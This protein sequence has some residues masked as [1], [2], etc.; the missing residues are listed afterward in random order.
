MT[1]GTKS[2]EKAAREFWLQ[3]TRNIQDETFVHEAPIDTDRG[4]V[5]HVIEFTAYEKLELECAGLR[6]DLETIRNYEKSELGKAHA[7]IRDLRTTL[8]FRNCE[9][10]APLYCCDG[11]ECG[12]YGLPIDYEVT[13]ECKDG[14][15]RHNW[16][17]KGLRGALGQLRL[18]LGDCEQ[19]KE[20]I[21]STLKDSEEQ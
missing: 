18:H 2:E 14:C 5:V 15:E 16:K 9:S 13:D 4:D 19:A 20:Y 21:D 11:R 17:A 7:L 3:F 6:A 10:C 1:P 8:H 12:C